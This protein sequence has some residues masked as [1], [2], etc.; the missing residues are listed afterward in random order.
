MSGDVG[1]SF[2]IRVRT[3]LNQDEGRASV[4]NLVSRC[5]HDVLYRLDSATGPSGVDS[6]ED[7]PDPGI[8]AQYEEFR[9]WFGPEVG[10]SIQSMV[11]GPLLS[12]LS[13]SMGGLASIEDEEY[14]HFLPEGDKVRARI[15]WVCEELPELIEN[16]G[17]VDGLER[18]DALACVAQGYALLERY[19]EKHAKRM[20][21]TLLPEL[22]Q[23]FLLCQPGS[24]SIRGDKEST[25]AFLDLLDDVKR[26][27]AKLQAD[28]EAA[29]E[30]I[31]SE[32]PEEFSAE[33]MEVE[34][35]RVEE[36]IAKLEERLGDLDK[37]RE[38]IIERLS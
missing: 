25:K 17:Q 20:A 28:Q 24:K 18:E 29:Q 31:Q 34:L 15:Q 13:V 30:A 6:V 26:R 16:Y 12:R 35:E 32:K 3:F 1:G 33:A 36:Q 11:V 4:F 8:S 23:W 22:E 5:V 27:V 14:R 38:A 37:R 9:D 21:I 19:K 7:P 2:N 10:A